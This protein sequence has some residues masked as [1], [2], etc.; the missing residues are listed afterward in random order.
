MSLFNKK[1][2]KYQLYN[3]VYT[4]GLDT[5]RTFVKAKDLSNLQKAIRKQNYISG[6]IS[7]ETV[8]KIE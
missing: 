4:Y 7:I 3:V 6:P 2:K 1:K 5:Y 8:I